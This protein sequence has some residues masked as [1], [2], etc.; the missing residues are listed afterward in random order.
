MLFHTFQAILYKTNSEP[1][2]DGDLDCGCSIPGELAETAGRYGKNYDGVADMYSA[3]VPKDFTVDKQ[4]WKPERQAHFEV[5][6]Y[7]FFFTFLL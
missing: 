6:F 5:D 4:Q 1:H 2:T 7:F 3:S